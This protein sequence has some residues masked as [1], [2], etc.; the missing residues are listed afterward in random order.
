MDKKFLNKVVDQLVSE[1]RISKRRAITL[2]LTPFSQKT[3]SAFDFSQGKDLHTKYSDVSVLFIYFN[4]H[5]KDVYSLDDTEIS[6][7]FSKYRNIIILKINGIIESYNKKHINEGH[8]TNIPEDD[9]TNRL[10]SMLN[11]PPYLHTLESMGLTEEDIIKAFK[12]MYGDVVK[13]RYKT[14]SVRVKDELRNTLYMEES[15]YDDRTLWSKWEWY[16]R[17]DEWR[18]FVDETGDR[19]YRTRGGVITYD[20][21]IEDCCPEELKDGFYPP[22]PT[23][24][25]E[26]DNKNV[27]YYQYV[28]DDKYLSRVLEQLLSETK[29]GWDTLRD[30]REISIKVGWDPFIGYQRDVSWELFKKHCQEVYSLKNVEISDIYNLYMMEIKKRLNQ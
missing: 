26:S 21:Q 3:F 23:N 16:P 5:C 17:S 2:I 9:F 30:G 8:V 25:N 12:K 19:R 28:F 24:I 10:V 6:Y 27:W 22:L 29:I 15:E 13:V 1:T 7:V 11:H 4:L 18:R 14:G 20:E